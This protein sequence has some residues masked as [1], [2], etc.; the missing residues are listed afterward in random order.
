MKIYIAGKITD[1]PEY[2]NQ[3]GEAENVLIKQ[4]HAVM[5]P[6][7]LPP[8]FE[9]YEYM[10]VCYSMIDVCEGV[11]FLENWQDS[12]GAK[13]EHEYASAGSKKMVYQG[14]A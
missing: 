7:I 4:G 9:H 5:N 11:Y 13:M 10:K 1:N 14:G 12:K 3:F 2:K 8:G 6:S